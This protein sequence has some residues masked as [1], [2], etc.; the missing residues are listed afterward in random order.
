MKAELVPVERPHVH[1]EWTNSPTHRTCEQAGWCCTR[2]GQDDKIDPRFCTKCGYT[3]F[4]PLWRLTP[5]KVE[6]S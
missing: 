3:V 4:A 6:T 5:R 2:C 1:G